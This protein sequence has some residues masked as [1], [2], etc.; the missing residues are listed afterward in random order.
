MLKCLTLAHIFIKIWSP[1]AHFGQRDLLRSGVCT[2]AANVLCLYIPAACLLSSFT[3][4]EGK[5][6]VKVR[7]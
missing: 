1:I 5:L 6:D 2:Y 4:K 7:G 3:H